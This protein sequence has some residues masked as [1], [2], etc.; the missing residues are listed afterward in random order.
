MANSGPKTGLKAAITRLPAVEP[1]RPAQQLA[2]FGGASPKDHAGGP[3][4]KQR[5]RPPGAMNRRTQ[6]MIDFIGKQYGLPVERLAKIY[7]RPYRELAA[8]LGVS[9]AEAV[10]LQRKAASDAAP[11]LHAKAT[12]DAVI[13]VNL[14][15]G[16][17]LRA[18]RERAEQYQG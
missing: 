15:F 5:G 8:E 13:N 12:P 7:S 11:Y 16:D 2:L 17:R 14:G 18:A 10:D 4:R 1:A 9:L 6:E 3:L